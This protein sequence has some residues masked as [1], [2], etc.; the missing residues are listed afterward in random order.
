VDWGQI[1]AKSSGEKTLKDDPERERQ[2]EFVMSGGSPTLSGGYFTVS[3]ARVAEA[4]VS[5]EAAP[6]DYE[7]YIRSYFISLSRL[8]D[9]AE[10][11]ASGGLGGKGVQ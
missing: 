7:E 1:R 10:N 3:S 9:S 5:R 4:A 6:R 8:T 2:F 11:P